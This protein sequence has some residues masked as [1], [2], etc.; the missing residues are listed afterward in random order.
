[1]IGEPVQG[2]GGV[3]VPPDAYW[4]AITPILKRHDILLIAD[5]V[6][7]GFGRTGQMFGPR[8]TGSSRTSPASPR[9]SPP[10]TSRSAGPS[11]PT[12]SST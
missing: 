4:D 9:A 3:I 7:S 10:A 8:P 2:A 5:E 6:I 11:S 1:M 12:R